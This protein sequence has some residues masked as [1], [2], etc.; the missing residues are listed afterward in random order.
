MVRGGGLQALVIP[1]RAAAPAPDPP[2]GD[3][4]SSLR[5]DWASRDEDRGAETQAGE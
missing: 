4:D 2:G 3:K 1:L 5:D